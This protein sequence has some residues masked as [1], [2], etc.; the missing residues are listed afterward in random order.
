VAGNSLATGEGNTFLGQHA[1]SE[2]TGGS[3]NLILGSSA[4]KNGGSGSY[5][6]IVG[7]E[8]GFESGGVSSG[9][10]FLG[11]QAG[12][13]ETGS[14]KLY[15]ANSSTPL[16]L[17][18]GDFSESRVRING[19]TVEPAYTFYV[20]GPAGGTGP[21]NSVSD[22]RLKTNVR[23]LEG[24]LSKVLQLNGV[25]FNWKDEAYHRPGENI[26][27]IAQDLLK[28]LPQ[29]VSGGGTDEQGNEVYY[30]VEY[31]TLTPVLVEAIKEQQKMIEELKA[32]IEQ[33]KKNQ[34]K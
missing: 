4:S 3:Y 2:K 18:Y 15:I 28:V 19:K 29:V 8:A 27:F 13:N 11:Y 34:A 30:S 31:A 10:V 25:T 21:W 22:G 6:T 17:I 33:L 14:N 5:N 1:G 7:S 24:A 16:P 20:Q 12:Y 9:N 32:E 26:G 23:P